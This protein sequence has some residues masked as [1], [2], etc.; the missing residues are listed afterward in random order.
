MAR[1]TATLRSPTTFS[2]LAL[3]SLV[4][5]TLI[6]VTGAAVRLTQSGLG[7]P[8]WPTCTQHS[9]VAAWSFHPMVEFSNRMVT[10][11]VVVVIGVTMVGAIA[12]MPRRRDLVWLSAA[13]VA[14]VVGQAVLGGMVVLYKLAPELVMAHFLVSMLMLWNA[15]VLYRRAARPA[16]PVKAMVSRDMV[17]LSRIVVAVV[18]LVL[19]LGTVVTGTGPHSGSPGTERLPFP[20]RDVAELHATVVLFLIGLTL[21]MLFGLHSSGAPARVQQRGRVLLEI[22]ALQGVIGYSQ[23]FTAVPAWLVEFH[24]L[25]AT[26]VWLAALNFHLGLF[27]GS[28][29]TTSPRPRAV[30]LADWA[31]PRAA[32]ALAGAGPPET[33]PSYV[34]AATGTRGSSGTDGVPMRHDQSFMGQNI[35]DDEQRSSS[36][37][38]C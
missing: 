31:E 20:L 18:A 35:S 15:I 33:S 19:F 26:T 8:D 6:V 16:G 11:A 23:Y 10:I 17:R 7:C 2:R 21:A 38:P 9:L 13:L 28:S 12:R 36:G 24:V 29:E 30:P 1:S 37:G 4:S 3:A 5:L 32:P 34:M 27:S 25:G 22:M 14:G